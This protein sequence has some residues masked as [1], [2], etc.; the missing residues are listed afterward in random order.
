MA[1]TLSHARNTV[2]PGAKLGESAQQQSGLEANG[3]FA[4]VLPSPQKEATHL[5]SEKAGPKTLKL[6]DICCGMGGWSIGFYR[7][8]FDCTGVDTLDIAYPYRLVQADV[9]TWHPDQDYD[10]VTASPPCTEFSSLTRLAIARGQRGPRDIPAG[11]EIVKGCIRIIEE[12]KPRFWILENVHGSEEHIIPLLGNPKI[13]RGPWR[14][15]GDFPSFI[16]PECPKSMKKTGGEIGGERYHREQACHDK[17]NSVFAFNPLRSWFRS[18]IP[19][20]LS[21]PLA[22]ACREA[23]LCKA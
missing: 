21:V 15:W 9:R 23:F 18:K 8:G 13:K 20:P 5:F 7:A 6:L 1:P 14:L 10:I 19:I 2:E 22:K 17:L 12:V 11:V 16:L 3:A 4:H